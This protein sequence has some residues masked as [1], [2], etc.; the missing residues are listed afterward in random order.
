MN[1]VPQFIRNACR[2]L[3]FLPQAAIPAEAGIQGGI[4]LREN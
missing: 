2:I 3:P 4:R 1:S